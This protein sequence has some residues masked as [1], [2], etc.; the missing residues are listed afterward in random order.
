MPCNQAKQT[1]A[2]QPNEKNSKAVGH[3]NPPMTAL[4]HGLLCSLRRRR[5]LKR[6]PRSSL[7]TLRHWP[8]T[9][10]AA[11]MIKH[12]C[13]LMHVCSSSLPS[14]TAW[15]PSR[16]AWSHTPR[17]RFGSVASVPTA[18]QRAY[19]ASAPSL[20]PRASDECSILFFA[21]DG[22]VQQIKSDP[23]SFID[24]NVTG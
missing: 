1:S 13:W 21:F 11:A 17:R 12:H 23:H 15:P 19:R 2:K 24:N 5:R 20:T 22:C 9:R 14:S 3:H 10:F 4:I 8:E 6:L 16:R 18:W 7:S